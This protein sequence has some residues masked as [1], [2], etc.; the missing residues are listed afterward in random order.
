[1]DSH[2]I[3]FFPL[4]KWAYSEF[5]SIIPNVKSVNQINEF[6]IT[7]KKGKKTDMMRFSSEHRADILTAALVSYD[8]WWTALVEI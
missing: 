8:D 5:I 1:M 4:F 7:M 3:V 2:N 6:S